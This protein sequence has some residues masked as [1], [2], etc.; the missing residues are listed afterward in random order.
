M[1]VS[2]TK[3]RPPSKLS[4]LSFIVWVAFL[5]ASTG[6]DIQ[7]VAIRPTGFIGVGGK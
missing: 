7:E 6:S 4:G 5:V 3:E 2:K 1:F